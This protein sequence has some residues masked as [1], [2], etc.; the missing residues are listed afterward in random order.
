MLCNGDF[1]GL[2]IGYIYVGYIIPNCSIVRSFTCELTYTLFIRSTANSEMQLSVLVLLAQLVG[3][4]LSCVLQVDLKSGNEKRSSYPTS[5]KAYLVDIGT[6]VTITCN[7]GQVKR[8]GHTGSWSS[9]HK[10]EADQ[11]TQSTYTCACDSVGSVSV[12]ITLKPTFS[13]VEN[14]RK[15][16]AGEDVSISCLEDNPND[17]FGVRWL[18]RDEASGSSESACDLQGYHCA[19]AGLTISNA[20]SGHRGNYL[21][22]IASV[23]SYKN[24]ETWPASELSAA[25][26]LTVAGSLCRQYCLHSLP[27]LQTTVIKYV[28]LLL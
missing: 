2:F 20:S 16:C 1:L 10:F 5:P 4:A 22:R 24:V 18:F 11:T 13:E 9:P 14:S 8:D 19:S 25:T 12:F 23:N 3:L 27:C 7:E 6:K 26:R 21:C 15:V 17:I 28:Y